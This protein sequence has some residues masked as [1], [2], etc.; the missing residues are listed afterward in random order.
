MEAEHD[1]GWHPRNLIE[2]LRVWSIEIELRTLELRRCARI[3]T[4]IHY[5]IRMPILLLTTI[6]TGL[7]T[8]SAALDSE[9]SQELGNSRFAISAIVLNSASI[10]LAGIDTALG[11]AKCASASSICA[12]EYSS[13]STE[14]N[15]EIDELFIQMMDPEFLASTPGTPIVAFRAIRAKYLPKQQE[16]M[17]DE[18]N[19]IFFRRS[20]LKKHVGQVA[21]G[22]R[23]CGIDRSKIASIQDRSKQANQSSIP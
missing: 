14:L 12:R 3:W 11:A 19:N 7:M 20:L 17:N 1:P 8:L 5:A 10:F 15:F 4:F 21:I 6:A 13:L 16:I 22:E 9:K 2:I 23:M 18:P